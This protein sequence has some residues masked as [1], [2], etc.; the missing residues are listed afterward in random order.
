[1]NMSFSITTPQFLDRTKTV[2]RRLGWRSAVPGQVITAVEKGMGL[3]RGERVRVLGSI[4]VVDVRTEALDRMSQQPA[5]GL[6]EAVLEGFPEL[7]GRGFVSM[8]CE[9]NR[10]LPT[11][12]VR[13]IQFEYLLVDCRR[14]GGPGHSIEEGATCARCFLVA[15]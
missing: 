6:S 1:M 13:R 8:F 14:C 3:K 12:P 11:R 5:Y 7:D 15:F 4:R 10:C 2:T 9:A